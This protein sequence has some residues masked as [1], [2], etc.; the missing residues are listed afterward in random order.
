MA[1]RDFDGAE[2]L[3]LPRFAPELRCC[4]QDS[5]RRG[6]R[7]KPLRRNAL[8]PELRCL[9]DC[10]V[11]ASGPGPAVAG[12]F[13]QWSRDFSADTVSSSRDCGSAI[14]GGCPGRRRGIRDRRRAFCGDNHRGD[15]V[16]SR[17]RHRPP[18]GAGTSKARRPAGSR[19]NAV[20]PYEWRFLIPANIAAAGHPNLE[21]AVE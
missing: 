8:D 6:R 14:F 11:D 4:L 18:G 12:G 16:G 17:F 15:G 1:V 19:D 2:V 10:R 13:A 3:R 20:H 9:Q 5:P 7:A 21:T